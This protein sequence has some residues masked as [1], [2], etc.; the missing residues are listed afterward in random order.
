MKGELSLL[1]FE[2]FFNLFDIHTLDDRLE[3]LVL[4]IHPS[5]RGDGF[6]FTILAL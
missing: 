3:V 2:L 6:V 4:Q 5:F 1:G